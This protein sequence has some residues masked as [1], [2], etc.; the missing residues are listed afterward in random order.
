MRWS[1]LW[2]R[3]VF[4]EH[5]A[6]TPFA[7]PASRR[8]KH[9]LGSE[10]KHVYDVALRVHSMLGTRAALDAKRRA[11]RAYSTLPEARRDELAGSEFQILHDAYTRLAA[12]RAE[13]APVLRRSKSDRSE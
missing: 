13:W 10:Q 5:G 3:F 4:S 12:L 8:R 1:R 2:S 9:A 11:E 6:L 7:P